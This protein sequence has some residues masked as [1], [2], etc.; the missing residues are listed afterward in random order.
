MGRSRDMPLQGRGCA[1]QWRE[2]C[3]GRRRWWELG[4]RDPVAQG[5]WMEAGGGGGV[6]EASTACES[7]P[8]HHVCRQHRTLPP[9]SVGSPAGLVLGKARALL[10][11]GLVGRTER[12]A[13]CPTLAPCPHAGSR[14][15]PPSLAASGVRSGS[16]SAELQLSAGNRRHRLTSSFSCNVKL[17][18]RAWALP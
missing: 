11:G 5:Q 18:R 16:L 7:A 6:R 9:C 14:E 4:D 8:V 1:R 15:Q 2:R 13:Q 3:G 17:A 12:I 10:C